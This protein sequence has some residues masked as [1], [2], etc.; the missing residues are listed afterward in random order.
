MLVLRIV[1]ILAIVKMTRTRIWVYHIARLISCRC[2][3]RQRIL[4][5]P[6]GRTLDRWPRSCGWVGLIREVGLDRTLFGHR[7]WRVFAVLRLRVGWAAID[8]GI[9]HITCG[10]TTT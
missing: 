9:W 8:M 1:T 2:F 5:I 4:M 10:D 6:S 7:R 3:L